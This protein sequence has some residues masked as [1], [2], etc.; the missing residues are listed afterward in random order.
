[1]SMS[2]TSAAGF[3]EFVARY[4]IAIFV[5]LALLISWASVVPMQGGLIPH[6][7]MIAAFIVLAVVPGRRGVSELWR[8]MSRWRVGWK[9]YLIAPAIYITI[10]LLALAGSLA[11]GAE[12]VNTAHLR[13]LPAYLGLF[14]PLLFFGG[15]WEEPGWMGYLQ[16]RLQERRP[17]SPLL[18]ALVATPIRMIWHTPLLLYGTIPWHDYIFTSLALHITLTWLYNRTGSVLIPMICHLFSNVAFAT[19][20]PMIAPA[21][22]G[23]YWALFIT[24]QCL[25]AAGVA[26]S[27]RGRLGVKSRE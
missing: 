16:R 26:L 25:L 9:W 15:Q 1:M 7:P 27:T 8:Q 2:A 3:K 23:R 24:A 14:V 12:I 21:D 5:L 17:A 11:L 19:V 20:Y 13:S 22:Q 18:A 6:G 10:H 4:Q